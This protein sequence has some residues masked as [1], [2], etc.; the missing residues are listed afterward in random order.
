MTDLRY[1]GTAPN[2]YVFEGLSYFTCS[3]GFSYRSG[4]L[5]LMKPA[6]DVSETF[7]VKPE[8]IDKDETGFRSVERILDMFLKTKRLPVRQPF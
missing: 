1:L 7:L 4:D 8:D 6:D 2:E 5:H 3:T